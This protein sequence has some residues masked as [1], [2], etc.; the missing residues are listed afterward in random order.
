MNYDYDI[1]GMKKERGSPIWMLDNY[2][3]QYLQCL[4]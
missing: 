4:I 1:I 2:G 3:T